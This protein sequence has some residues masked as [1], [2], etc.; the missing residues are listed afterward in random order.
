MTLAGHRGAPLL[1]RGA[2][3]GWG[4]G[5]HTGAP[6]DVSAVQ[7]PDPAPPG[8]AE[9]W[10]FGGHVGA[11]TDVSAVQRPDPAPPGRA[12]CWG[13]GGHVGASMFK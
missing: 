6:T 7:K 1:R 11:P 8:W 10:G 5:G 13:F 3:S 9:R 4:V 2:P 12:E